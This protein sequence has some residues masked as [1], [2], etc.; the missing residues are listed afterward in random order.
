MVTLPSRRRLFEILFEGMP[1]GCFLVDKNLEIIAF[2]KAAE[3]LTG[4]KRDEVIGKPCRQ[5]MHSNLCGQFCPLKEDSSVKKAYIAREATIKN[6]FGEEIPICFSSSK[7]FDS[8]GHFEVGIEIFRDR[9]DDERL[10]TLRNHIISIFAHD[11]KTPV[12]VTGGLVHRILAGKAGPVTE[13][14][15]EYL[16]IILKE[17]MQ[18][19]LLINSL[20]ELLSIESGRTQP[21]KIATDLHTFLEEA[22][23]EIHPK[24]EANH[25]KLVFSVDD[26]IKKPVYLDKIQIKRVVINLLDNA[27]KYSP[28]GSTVEL[29]VE[30]KDDWLIFKVK[31]QGIGIPKEDLPHIFEYFFRASNSRQKADGTGLGLASARAIVESNGGRIWAKSQEG[32]G[33]TFFIRL[34]YEP[35]P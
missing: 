27:I 17:N 23:K 26:S 21:Q 5:V 34:P 1:T 11:I 20:L 28:K 14:Q 35:D 19:E 4:W 31:D 9:G 32:L 8:T 25:I 12:S 33:T 10:Q 7:V 6:K 18:V 30:L 13:K 2:N 16:E 22:I 15:R 3:R 29:A 24:A